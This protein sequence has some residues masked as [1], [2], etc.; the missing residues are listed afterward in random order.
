MSSVYQKANPDG[1]DVRITVG[2]AVS[3][4]KELDEWGLA[5]GATSRSQ[6][7]RMVMHKVLSKGQP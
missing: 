6:A 4:V 2:M 3:L 7:L 5:H 1:P